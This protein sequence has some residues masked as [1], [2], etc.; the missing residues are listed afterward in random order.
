[1]KNPWIGTIVLAFCLAANSFAQDAENAPP[2]V[3]QG[4]EALPSLHD[5]KEPAA[6]SQP[7]GSQDDKAAN[8]IAQDVENAPPEVKQGAEELPSLHDGKE[9][10]APSQPPGTQDDKKDVVIPE[11]GPVCAADEW[12]N[13]PRMLCGFY[14]SAEYLLW[15]MKKGTSL[16][17]LVTLGDPKDTPTGALGQPGTTVLFGGDRF[18]SDPFSGGRFLLGYWFGQEHAW[19]LEVGFF[20]L[21]QRRSFFSAS[22]TGDPGTGSLN[23][24]F[25]NGDGKFEDSFPQVALAGTAEGGVAIRLTQRLWGTEANLR[26]AAVDNECFRLSWL[27]GFRVIDLEESF[28]LG[29]T[30]AFL[31]TSLG[32]ATAL[33]DSIATRNRFYGAQIGADADIFRGNFRLNLNAKLALGGTAEQVNISGT[34]LNVNPIMGMVV[35]PGGYFSGPNNIG[36]H[37][38][39]EFAVVPEIGVNLGYQFS[40]SVS[41]MIGYNFLFISDVVRPSDQIDRTVTVQSNDHPG[42]L[43]QRTDFW[44]Q[45]ITFGVQFRY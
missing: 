22:G 44:A 28:D 40:Q 13:Q 15:W 43:F 33:N 4:T 36:T 3:K 23:V 35:A 14:G 7:P 21:Q 26:R 20:F 41:A 45:G 39:S 2:E 24:V 29:T 30:T 18:G 17:P 42:V 11:A 37:S 34:I 25:F 27:V 32:I 5:G 8:G 6:A 10:A 1:M 16:P 38:R 12:N 31:P 19:G 9:P